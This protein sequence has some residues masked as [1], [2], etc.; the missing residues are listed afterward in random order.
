[1][2]CKAQPAAAHISAMDTPLDH[3]QDEAMPLVV[4]ALTLMGHSWPKEEYASL[5]ESI[6]HLDSLCFVTRRPLGAAAKAYKE[7]FR[8]PKGGGTLNINSQR[9][10]RAE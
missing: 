5:I 10:D 8:L 3:A 2:N 9:P 4:W 7:L 6:I 1:M